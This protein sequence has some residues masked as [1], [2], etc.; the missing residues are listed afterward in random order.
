MASGSKPQEEGAGLLSRARQRRRTSPISSLT[1]VRPMTFAT[2][3]AADQNNTY[4]SCMFP[5]ITRE[6]RKSVP[7]KTDRLHPVSGT[8]SFWVMRIH[9]SAARR[10]PIL[11]VSY[12]MSDRFKKKRAQKDTT[13]THGYRISILSPQT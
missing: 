7:G 9:P 6:S 4:Y 10:N 2:V 3:T 1:R 11:L 5:G 13:L 8:S 12:K